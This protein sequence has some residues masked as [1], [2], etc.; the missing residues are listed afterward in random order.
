MSGT[1][2]IAPQSRGRHRGCPHRGCQS[3]AANHSR[4]R[5]LPRGSVARTPRVGR[6]E[7]LR[8]NLTLMVG[9]GLVLLVGGQPGDAHRAV[10]QLTG[11]QLTGGQFTGVQLTP[12]P[13]PPTPPGS[14]SPRSLQLVFSSLRDRPAFASLLV[15]RHDGVATGQIVGRLPV[16][17]DTSFT[18]C[19]LAVEGRLGLFNVKQTGGFLPEVRLWDPSR[20]GTPATRW[21][22]ADP[23]PGLRTDA[24]LSPD[25]RFVACCVLDAVGEPG[26]WD[27]QLFDRQTGRQIPLPGF[28]SAE[29]EREVTLSANARWLACTSDRPGGRGLAEVLLYDR[30]LGRLCDT[31]ELNSPGRELN[32]ALSADGDWLAFIT[33]REGVTAGKDLWLWERATGRVSPLAGANGPGHEQSPAFSPDGRWVVFVS[34]R[35]RGAGE[36]DL[37]LLDRQT[38]RLVPTPGLNSAAEDFD[39]TLAW[40]P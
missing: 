23:Q 24:V 7:R 15:Y 3:C 18:R 37:Y 32:P 10:A 2:R 26:G 19:S 12:T 40:A 27:V 39:P 34:E 17:P 36:R 1:A 16:E 14:L 5:E 6:Q 29:N 33:D 8:S 31:A 21:P 9:L 13:S 20:A 25:G 22:P 11:G 35:V 38:G 4:E 28:N 30:E